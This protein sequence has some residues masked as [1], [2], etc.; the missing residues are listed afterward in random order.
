M[1]AFAF[2]KK[3]PTCSR[4]SRVHELNEVQTECTGSKCLVKIQSNSI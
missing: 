1:C 2:I 3:N 4:F